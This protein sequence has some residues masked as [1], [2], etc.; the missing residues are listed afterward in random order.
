MARDVLNGSK[1]SDA[2]ESIMK[3][4]LS[5]PPKNDRLEQIVEKAVMHFNL[6]R[7]L[8][9]GEFTTIFYVLFVF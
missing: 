5:S 7:A 2:Q 3:R 9:S 1:L 8:I 6:D 4:V